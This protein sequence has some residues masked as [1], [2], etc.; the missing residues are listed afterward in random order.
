MNE[1][2]SFQKMISPI[3]IKA[4]FWLC[5]LGVVIYGLVTI[6]GGSFFMGLL[7][8]IVGPLVIRIYCELL[9]VLFQINNT[10]TE[11]KNMKAGS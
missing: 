2:L 5:I 8:L 4:L 11:I 7:I 1:Y 10:L 3:I 9:I 6:F